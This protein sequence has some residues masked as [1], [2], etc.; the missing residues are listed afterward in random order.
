MK[1]DRKERRKEGSNIR[2]TEREKKIRN[3]EGYLMK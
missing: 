1:A 3:K 2:K